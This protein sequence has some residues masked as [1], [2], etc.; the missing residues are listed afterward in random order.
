[1]NKRLSAA[2]LHGIYAAIPTPTTAEGIVNEPAARTLMDY[3]IQGGANGV[4][5]LGGT[6]EFCSLSHE[7]RVLMVSACAQAADGRM[8]VIA[9]ILHPGF[10]DAMES[11]KA[12]SDAGADALMLLT[13]YYT[14]PSQVGIRDY[15]IRFADESPAPVMIYE[16]PYRTGISISPEIIHEL[17]RHENIIGM[18]V[19]NTDTYQFLKI[20]S[21]ISD[22]FSVFSGEDTLFPLHMAGGAKGGIIVT[23]TLLPKIWR[24][25]Y[26]AGSSG[27][28]AAAFSM[29]RKL[30]PILDL[31]F[32]EVNPGPLKSV[33]DL[34]GVDA[35][36]VLPPLV[37]TNADL[38]KMLRAE[39]SALL[40][41]EA[42]IA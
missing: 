29:H 32:A 42:G 5:A 12:F 23:A 1:M 18:K 38:S 36:C 28:H 33:W 6:G 22:S 14:T 41:D 31:S 24:A 9:G 26:Q 34:I 39:L 13:P 19:S 16:I 35:P 27:N 17:S 7:Q 15:F 10:H 21:G 11:G 8:P 2:D 37:S 4:L 25:M 40:K 3:L 30:I 20:V